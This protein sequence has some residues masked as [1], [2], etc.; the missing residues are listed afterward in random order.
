[1]AF[2]CQLVQG[3]MGEFTGLLNAELATAKWLICHVS[4]SRLAYQLH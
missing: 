2:G 4:F 3:L 1:M